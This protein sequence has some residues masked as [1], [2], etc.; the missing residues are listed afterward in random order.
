M[1]KALLSAVCVLLIYFPEAQI[2]TQT[3]TCTDIYFSRP[4]NW[5]TTAWQNTVS[6]DNTYIS[7]NNLRITSSRPVQF[8]K[9]GF[10]I[11]T[12]A[13]IQGVDVA[14]IR[15]KSGR[16]NVQD[17]F[18][19]LVTGDDFANSG[20]NT[21]SQA[22]S[23]Y[24]TTSEAGVVYTFPASGTGTD[25]NP[26]SW[27][28]GKINKPYFGF[29]FDIG[30]SSGSGAVAKIEKL[31]ITVR[32]TLSTTV[33]NNLQ[34]TP[35]DNSVLASANEKGLYNLVVTDMSGR[36]LQRAVLKDPNNTTVYLNHQLRG[37]YIISLEGNN[38]KKVI[39][40]FVR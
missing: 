40:T 34:L 31:S 17:A 27:T 28:P 8:Q 23:A 30:V 14:M 35:V 11:P 38:S 24:W 4:S 32:Y 33:S 36:V 25:G 20:S 6:D 19:S 29:F 16:S 37:V 2:Y 26:Y 15:L 1:K 7:T 12:N 13:V 9:F 5:A 22:K 18:A 39:K 21:P 3:R 10:S